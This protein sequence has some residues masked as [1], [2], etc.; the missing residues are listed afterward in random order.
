MSHLPNG[1][2]FDWRMGENVISWDID[3]F[4]PQ[5]TPGGKKDLFDGNQALRIAPQRLLVDNI[6]QHFEKPSIQGRLE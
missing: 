1:Y 4:Y 6:L 3:N 5:I 2:L